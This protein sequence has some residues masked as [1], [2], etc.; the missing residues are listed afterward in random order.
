MS[1]FFL[2]SD[3]LWVSESYLEMERVCASSSTETYAFAAARL[4][5]AL[6][7]EMQEPHCDPAEITIS[8]GSVDSD[9]EDFLIDAG[10]LNLV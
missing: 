6:L 4:D 1:D 8:I 2:P 3:Q 5:R 9:V 7:V 10:W